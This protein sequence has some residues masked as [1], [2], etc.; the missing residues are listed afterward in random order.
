MLLT[1]NDKGLGILYTEWLN[2]AFNK[3]KITIINQWILIWIKFIKLPISKN[4]QRKNYLLY[5]LL[6]VK[7]NWHY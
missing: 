4:F 2:G 5:I 3:L 7:I 1:M 6:D